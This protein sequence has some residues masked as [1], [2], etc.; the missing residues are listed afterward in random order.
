MPQPLTSVQIGPHTYWIGGW[1]DPTAD[2]D[3]LELNPK[4]PSLQPSH[5]TDYTTPALN[6]KLKVV[7]IIEHNRFM[8]SNNNWIMLRDFIFYTH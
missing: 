2:L 4:S 1:V 3:I 8:Y 6:N 7:Y 5:Y